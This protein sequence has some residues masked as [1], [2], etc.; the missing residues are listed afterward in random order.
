MR[1]RK[2]GIFEELDIFALERRDEEG[3][4]LSSEVERS[5]QKGGVIGSE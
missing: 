1:S 5:F 3:T 2:D 4:S